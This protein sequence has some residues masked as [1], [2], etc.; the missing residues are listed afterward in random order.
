MSLQQAID[1]LKAASPWALPAVILLVA[2]LFYGPIRAFMKNATRV[3]FG[4]LAIEIKRIAENSRQALLDTSSLQIVLAESRIV[5]LEH[6]LSLGMV[7]SDQKEK[8]ATDLT[9]IRGE[10]DRLRLLRQNLLRGNADK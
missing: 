1:F 9:R 6:I 2:V 10:L 7:A 4:P 8:L 3:E 5:E